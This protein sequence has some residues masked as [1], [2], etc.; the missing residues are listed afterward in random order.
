MNFLNRLKFYLIGFGL[1]LFLIYTLFKDREWDWLPE[2]KVKKFILENPIKINLRKDQTKILTD[3]FSKNIFDLITNG[4]VNFSKSETKA[5][6]K[7]Y[8]IE[9]NSSSAIFNISFEDT[10]CRIISIDNMLFKEN[11][12]LESLDTIVYMDRSNLYLM[13]EKMEKKFTKNF[14]SKAEKY[15]LNTDEIIRNIIHF[16]VNWKKSNPFSNLNPNYT[17]TIYISNLQYKISLETG[18]NKLRFKDISEI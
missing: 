4:N 1:G 7:K 13:F 17:G 2:N 8:I 11:N 3:Q 10:L 14:L 15:S 12:I 16:E 9:Y 18:N 5:V 6:D